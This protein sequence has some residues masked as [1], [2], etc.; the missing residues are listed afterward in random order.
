MRCLN[1]RSLYGL[2]T[3]RWCA[4]IGGFPIG[5]WMRSRT[6]LRGGCANWIGPGKLVGIYF[7]RSENPILAILAILKAGAAYVP[8]DPTFPVERIRHIVT[9]ADIALVMTDER[10]ASQAAEWFEGPCLSVDGD[11]EALAEQST[12]PLTRDETNVSPDDLAYVLYTSGT[13]GRPKGVMAEHR[14]VVRFVESFNEVIR[15]TSEDNVFQG[16]ALGFDGSVEEIWMAFS[17]GA[18]LVVGTTDAAQLGY[19]APRFSPSTG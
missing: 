11:R 2:T 7:H 14:N 13:T 6:S 4:A 17:N 8:I 18:T 19:E 10:L 12:E 5:L 9:E 15:L 1:R 16:F 3:L